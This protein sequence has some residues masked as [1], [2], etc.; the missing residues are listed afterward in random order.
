MNRASHP[1]VELR[2]LSKSFGDTRAVRELNLSIPAGMVYGLIGPNGAGKSTTI[3][4]IMGGLRA[5]S[6]SVR[7]AGLDPIADAGKVKPI[8]GY[9][10]E[11]H[12]ICRWMRAG[13]AVRFCRGLYPTWNDSLCDS[14][15]DQFGIERSKKV[16]HLSKG[17]LVKLALTLA[18]SHEPELLVM[19]EPTSGLDPMIREE[20]MDGVLRNMCDGRRTV[21][22]SSHT[23]SDVQR[24][25]DR[26]GIIGSGELLVDLPVDEL[27]RSTKLVRAVL[28]DGRLPAACPSGTIFERVDRREWSLTIRDYSP[29]RLEE[30][31]SANP[32]EHVEVC[33]LTLE[34]IFKAYVRGRRATA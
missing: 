9:V 20:L 28:C 11:V 8:V 34:E 10:P 1:V 13:E 18:L 29:D 31:R 23:L 25:A 6:G 22:F 16:R 7:V 14:L 12:H 19:D 5:T 3:K 2:G 33:D 4:V 26:I 27:L 30:L 21:L 32:V 15:L 24:L 17:T